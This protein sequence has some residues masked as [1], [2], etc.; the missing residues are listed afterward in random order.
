[1]V[2]RTAG[3][4]RQT[5][6]RLSSIGIGSICPT[7]ETK[8]VFIQ[9]AWTWP[10]GLSGKW[11]SL[12]TTTMQR[13]RNSETA[14]VK[15]LIIATTVFGFSARASAQHIDVGRTEYLSSCA[16]CHGID[17]KGNGPVSKELKTPPADL[18]ILAK[19][20]NGVFPYD[21]V[22]QMIDGR[23]STVVAHGTREMPIWGYRF[24]PPQAF[25]LK[26]RMLAVIEYL[27]TVQ[28]K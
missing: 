27:K 17:A 14:A 8:M 2:A 16:A 28:Q 5:A 20:N 15:W 23:N 12:E 19:N 13:T 24:G 7:K 26:N 22:Y 6:Q 3:D 25:R 9:C 11:H 1:M 4:R 10:N 21:T 18:T